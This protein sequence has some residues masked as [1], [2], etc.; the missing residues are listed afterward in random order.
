MRALALLNLM[1]M[2]LCA[3]QLRLGLIEVRSTVEHS[4]MFY[5]VP[6]LLLPLKP[7]P[8]HCRHHVIAIC[9]SADGEAM[10][11]R[12]QNWPLLSSPAAER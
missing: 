6:L 10:T 8:L 2:M 12:R 7:L 4:I 3:P 11:S 5:P 9:L 1:S